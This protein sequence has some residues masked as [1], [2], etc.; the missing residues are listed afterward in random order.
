[1]FLSELFAD[2]MGGGGSSMNS[3]KL[4]KKAG[5]IRGISSRKTQ[6]QNRGGVLLIFENRR[7]SA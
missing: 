5:R 6:P 7:N 1:M 3:Q 2:K 4:G